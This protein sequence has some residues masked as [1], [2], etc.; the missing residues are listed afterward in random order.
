MT[1]TEFPGGTRIAFP[2]GA[3]HPEV[4]IKEDGSTELSWSGSLYSDSD[5]PDVWVVTLSPDGST[6]HVRVDVDGAGWLPEIQET[7]RTVTQSRTVFV[8]LCM[9]WTAH[10]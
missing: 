6:V 4:L 3:Q 2:D 7:I 10:A 9:G 5:Q 1:T 8:H